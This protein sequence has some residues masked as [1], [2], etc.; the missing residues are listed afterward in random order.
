[1]GIQNIFNLLGA[2]VFA[3]SNDE[4]LLPAGYDEAT[5]GCQHSKVTGVKV[6]PGPIARITTIASAIVLG[7]DMIELD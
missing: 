4:I 3:A 6:F 2:D 5:L 7:T 1:M